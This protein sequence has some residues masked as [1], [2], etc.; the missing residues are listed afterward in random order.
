MNAQ[1]EQVLQLVMANEPLEHIAPLVK[2]LNLAHFDISQ[3][4]NPAYLM[5]LI[6]LLGLYSEVRQSRSH[7]IEEMIHQE[8]SNLLPCREATERKAEIRQWLENFPSYK[9]TPR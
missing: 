6:R 2:D 5:R 9:E 4:P 8:G 7:A 3:I 1:A